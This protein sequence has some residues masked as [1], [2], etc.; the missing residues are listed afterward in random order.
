MKLLKVFSIFVLVLFFLQQ[1][2]NKIPTAL[3]KNTATN[4][5]FILNNNSIKFNSFDLCSEQQILS[6]WNRNAG[7][8]KIKEVCNKILNMGFSYEV[9]ANFMFPGIDKVF[10]TF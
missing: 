10:D 3:A 2:P 9:C 8:E 7:G 4:F 6:K 5:E 1:N